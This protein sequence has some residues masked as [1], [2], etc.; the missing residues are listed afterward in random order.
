M[1]NE[2]EAGSPFVVLH[3]GRF[4]RVY[5]AEVRAGSGGAVAQ[6]AWKVRS[7]STPSRLSSRALTNLDVDDL[8][9][10]EIDG[11]NRVESPHVVAP[12][13]VPDALLASRPI[14]YCK[15]TDRYFHPVG[16]DSGLPLSVCKDD[17]LLADCGLVP[18]SQ[19][20]WRYLFDGET[21]GGSQ[22]FYRVAGSNSERPR[23][24]VVVRTG[25]QLFADWSRLVHADGGSEVV[26]RAAPFL[27]C[28][29]CEHRRS[30]Y[31][32]GAAQPLPA[33]QHLHVVSFYDVSSV[34]LELFDFDFDQI[35]D[36]LGG[37]DPAHVL[38]A[39]SAS[40]QRWL[41]ARTAALSSP[42]QWLF[43][44]DAGRFPLE[45]LS[46]KLAAFREV[47]DGLR[48]V[49]AVGR[50]HLAVAPANVMARLV[51]PVTGAPVRWGF[52]LALLDL[53]SPI[54]AAA[55]PAPGAR[56]PASGWLE[57]GPELRE[58]LGMRPFLAP[59]LQGNDGG[60]VVMS[61]GCRLVT[62]AGGKERLVVEAQGTGTLP[63]F[64][65]GDVA[66]V[67]PMGG[68]MAGEPALPTQIVE[69]R[70]RSVVAGTDIDGN[71]PCR[72]WHGKTFEAR[73]TFFRSLGPS[74]DLFGLGM[75][76]FRT[77]LVNDEHT[78][79]EV[80]AAVAR[81]V[82]RLE[83]EQPGSVFDEQPTVARLEQLV[84]G[85]EMQAFFDPANVLYGLADREDYARAAGHAPAID[86]GIWRSVLMIAFKLV[87]QWQGFSYSHSH[88][89]TSPFLLR[90]LGDD[91]EA[92]RRRLHV[93]MFLSRARDDAMAVACAEHLEQLRSDMMSSS[94][95]SSNSR[96]VAA[97]GRGGG[98]RLVVTREDG[99]GAPIEYQFDRE[100]VTIGRR[101]V[102]NL[103]RLNDPMVSS[104]HALIELQPDGYVVIDRGSTNGT[105]VDGI[106][107]PVEV[108]QPLQDG[109]VILVRPYQL[110]FHTSEA[111]REAPASATTVD[112][113]ELV[114]LMRIEFARCY[115]APAAEQHDA[116]RQ[117]LKR[118]R[119]TLG[120]PA[121]HAR[122]DEVLG[123]LR[124]REVA[125]QG[126]A[127]EQQAKFFMSAHRSMS[128]LART[129]LGSGE[130][131]SVDDVRA[132]AGKLARFV[133][134]TTQWIERSLDLRRVLGKHLELGSTG[135][136][137]GRAPVRTAAD[138]R[139]LVLG[140]SSPAAEPTTYFL[141]KFYDD[142]AAIVE[143]LLGGAQQVRR[144]VRE[145]LD[146][147]RLTE[148]AGREAKF[149]LL[150]NAAAN[151]SLWK[152]YVQTF[153]QVTAGQEFEAE[154]DRILQKS[155]QDHRTT[156]R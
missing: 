39:R 56:E 119:E 49:H 77:V 152:L 148:L 112:A 15:K 130:F 70:G 101:E 35:C 36:L 140:W 71:H 156:E 82:R 32:G 29:G 18:Y 14:V 72:S 149:G 44:G 59:F 23:N 74:A 116:L 129:L 121:L 22:T 150:V 34:A 55:G 91:L 88:A 139:Q 6:F 135:T 21:N 117:V 131:Q 95:V 7:D 66:H 146:P 126:E 83:D 41:E 5:L 30:C 132:F 43:G 4:S 92:L 31:P 86:L 37:A 63:R 50:P 33:E 48:A 136:G 58:D 84:T 80:A 141:A 124:G 85:P 78:M 45:V 19:D 118:A 134:T 93:D 46:Q 145:Q 147:A 138:V 27:P 81:C 75:L 154:L 73:V 54:A 122:I 47:C 123:R 113:G 25:S 76:L 104:M 106:R 24:G 53:G 79:E 98:F 99:T 102:E 68:A 60:G 115:D 94:A 17:G 51:G 110:V 40:S 3:E 151:S 90:Q 11:G 61:V 144:A 107:L 114:D 105:E 111:H 153:Q 8:W 65:A 67:Q 143:G 155:L 13:A 100:Q 38:Q 42:G 12:V 133:E 62:E 96:I 108:G 89:E 127:A 97:K 2:G 109:S 125:H 1:R 10:R 87:T 120:A 137:S 103:V 28:I 52:H 69:M 128:Q 26:Q 142:F 9:Q 16:A 64:R 57:P 20:T